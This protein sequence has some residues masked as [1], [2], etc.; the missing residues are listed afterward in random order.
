MI[1]TS[2]RLGPAA[3]TGN[4]TRRQ[5]VEDTLRFVEPASDGMPKKPRIALTGAVG[6]AGKDDLEDS[7]GAHKGRNVGQKVDHAEKAA[8]A[9]LLEE[10]HR[11]H[12]RHHQLRRDGAQRVVEGR[13]QRIP[14]LASPGR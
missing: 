4:C 8:P 9:N 6:P 5:Q 13:Q 1:T 10:Q 3:H 11:Q 7:G 14:P 12:Q 2:A